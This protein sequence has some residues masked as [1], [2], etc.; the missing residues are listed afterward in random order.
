MSNLSRVFG[1]TKLLIQERVWKTEAAVPAH[2]EW[3][4]RWAEVNNEE[5][6]DLDRGIRIALF[7]RCQCWEDSWVTWGTEAWTHRGWATGNHYIWRGCRIYGWRHSWVNWF[8]SMH[9]IV[10]IFWFQIIGRRQ[11]GRYP[12][13][14]R[15]LV[16]RILNLSGVLHSRQIFSGLAEP[17]RTLPHGNVL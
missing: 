8:I 6:S 5:C 13:V 2:S 4:Q 17:Q 7:R 9:N 1:I 10:W 14:A 11:S 15:R 16:I 12:C 3:V